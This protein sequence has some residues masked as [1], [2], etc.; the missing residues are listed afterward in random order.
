MVSIYPKN[1]KEKLLKFGSL[2]NWAK[3]DNPELY[4][5][6]LN[7]KDEERENDIEKTDY[8]F[9]LELVNL[10]K[11][12][13]DEGN[14]KNPF[15]CISKKTNEWYYFNNKN[16]WEHDDCGNNVRKKISNELREFY[17][18]ILDKAYAELKQTADREKGAGIKSLIAKYKDYVGKFAH[19]NDKKNIMTELQ[20][21]TYDSKFQQS[22][23]KELYTL[24]LNNKTVINLKTLEIKDRTNES[25]FSIECDVKYVELTPEQDADIKIYFMDLFSHNESV[26]QCVLNILKSAMTGK[27][28][29]YIFFAT[30]SGRNGKSL[31]FK[32]INKI[33]N[34]F[35]DTIS[36]SVIVKSKANSNLNTE[37]EKLDKIR[38]GFVSE[39]EEKDELNTKLI[40]EITG[41]DEIDLRTICKTNTT[42]KPTSN[43]FIATNEM[44]SFKVIQAVVDRIIV[45]PFNNRFEVDTTF[46]DTMIS[47]K[48]LV[49]SYILKHGVVCDKFDDLPEE[50]IQAKENYVDD[51]NDD[52]LREFIEYTYDYIPN[53][54]VQR[55]DFVMDMNEYFTRMSYRRD[56]RSEKKLTRDLKTYNITSCR[57]NSIV[58]YNGLKKKVIDILCIQDDEDEP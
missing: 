48:E 34:G 46:E 52:K 10:T 50:M 9:A 20:E 54:R 15:V 42:I 32:L 30:G 33:M 39:L 8:D 25:K 56:A 4:R 47:K 12:Y 43:L 29:R 13:D 27:M 21:I 17:N 14:H 53:S 28:L 49:F 31:L 58:Y 44:P 37:V 40:R 6:L 38:I 3:E 18:D 45:I 19:T 24:P 41:G 51:N 23:N 1:S 22:L 26:V 36:K 35:M 2:M 57:S 55:Q 5:Q 7:L 11:Q 16:I